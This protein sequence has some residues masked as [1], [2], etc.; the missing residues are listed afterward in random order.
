MTAATL[1]IAALRRPDTASLTGDA[2]WVA[3]VAAQAADG[4]LTYVG[5][6]TFG[7]SIEANP[8]LAWCIASGGAGLA[9]VAAKMLALG[10]GTLLHI[11]GMHRSIVLLTTVYAG[12]AI[13]RWVTVLWPGLF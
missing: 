12:A 3:F 8:L 5:V 11:Q 6:Y 1:R 13:W 9:L 2:I 10:C 4:V 7:P